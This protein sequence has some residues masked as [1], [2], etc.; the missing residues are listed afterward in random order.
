MG[1]GLLV[2]AAVLGAAIASSAGLEEPAALAGP[3]AGDDRWAVVVGITKYQGRTKPT[4]A[5]AAD[6]HDMREILLRHGFALNRIITLTDGEA[7][8]D[9]TRAALRWLVDNSSAGS[10]SVFHF[11][12][13]VKLMGR[14]RDRDGEK[15]DEYLWLSNNKF[16]ADAELAA[17]ARALR[18]RAW[19]NI[20]GCEAAGFND[21]IAGPQRLFTASSQ[22][23]QK[24]Y[25]YPPWNNS[26]YVGLLDRAILN[27]EG[28]ADGNGKVSIHE[29]Y[30]YAAP[31]APKMTAKQAKGPQHLFMA[32]GDGEEWFLDGPPAP[33][34]APEPDGDGQP[35]KSC[36]VDGICV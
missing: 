17:Y 23:P 1:R 18:G 2:I 19:I 36:P 9:R 27:R 32:G 16:I 24:S 26:V 5:G 10:F 6:A 7:T 12:G 20:A 11:S 30:A 15:V 35:P 28:D 3:G 29:A 33:P 21:G 14:D 31:I 4:A 25:E 34:P 22:E 13:H 8:A